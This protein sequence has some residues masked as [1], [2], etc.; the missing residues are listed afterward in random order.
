MLKGQDVIHVSLNKKLIVD[1]SNQVKAP[2]VVI[3]A[4]ATNCY[5]IVTHSFARLTAQHF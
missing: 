5:D 2:S 4:D 1:V 3:S